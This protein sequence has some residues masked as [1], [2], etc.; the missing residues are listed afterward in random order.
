MSNLAQQLN[1]IKHQQRSTSLTPNAQQPTL[2]LD[3]HTATTTSPDIF[4]TMAVIAY[5]RLS[6]EDPSIKIEGDVVMGS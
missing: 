1:K 4:Y 5:A 2:I 3:K 6:K